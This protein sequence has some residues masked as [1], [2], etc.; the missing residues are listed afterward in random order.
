MSK[1]FII[2]FL[3]LSLSLAFLVSP[4]EA[5]NRLEGKILLQVEST[6]EAWYVLP[7]IYERVY[8]GRPAQAFEIMRNFGLGISSSDLKLF[9]KE[10][11]P[12]SLGG[13]IV[14]A[15][16]QNGEAYYIN[17][18]DLK[19]HYLGR[20]AD[21]FIV[22]RNLGLGISNEDLISIPSRDHFILEEKVDVKEELEVE[23]KGDVKEELEVENRGE[24]IVDI[25]YVK[26]I[27]LSE[28]VK[29]LPYQ[30]DLI[31]FISQVEDVYQFVKYVNNYF[32][33][34]SNDSL[35]ASNYE[36]VYQQKQASMADLASLSNFVL[37]TKGCQSGVLRFNNQLVLV[38]RDEGLPKYLAFTD[39][40]VL[41]FEHGWSFRDIVLNESKRLKLTVDKYLYFGANTLDYRQAI[42]P[43]SWLNF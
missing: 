34:V 13:K 35:V 5:K 17:P 24:E 7:D 4:A 28:E 15:V 6:G 10:S 3:S 14:L 19:S 43:Y 31:T 27:E 11:F 12:E 2:Y 21:A 18:D 16:E 37:K 38:F 8:L 29:L 40:G 26:N 20:P 9:L 32:S 30:A 1:K 22:M 33:F 41:I 42:L 39:Q 25:D 23:D 36:S